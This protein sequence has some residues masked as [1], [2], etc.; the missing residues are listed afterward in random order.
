MGSLPLLLLPVSRGQG[1]PLPLV[2][3]H[4]FKTIALLLIMHVYTLP[5]SAF[6]LSV[7]RLPVSI[8]PVLL[9]AVCIYQS[10]LHMS[11]LYSFVMYLPVC[12]AV[13]CLY[14]TCATLSCLYLPVRTVHTS[15]VL[16]YVFTSLCCGYLSL[17]YLY[18]S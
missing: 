17:S 12:A 11:L 13:T 1:L 9:L 3:S 6:S 4:C 2:H 5:V 10:A 7:L 18:C 8:L 15:I 14:I 16:I